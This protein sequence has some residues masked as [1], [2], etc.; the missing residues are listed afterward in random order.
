MQSLSQNFHNLE[1]F[2]NPCRAQLLPGVQVRGGA[3]GVDSIVSLPCA[4]RA[5]TVVE[6][7]DVAVLA[8]EYV[9]SCR[10]DPQWWCATSDRLSFGIPVTSV[11]WDLLQECHM[12]KWCWCM[13]AIGIIAEA[14]WA[15][16]V[17]TSI[18]AF[19]SGKCKP[20]CMFPVVPCL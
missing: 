15:D 7:C 11:Q 14:T 17:A 8:D 16:D 13:S 9:W 2:Y 18:S 10:H 5:P 4:A 6:D 12:S 1:T 20:T 19:Q 3:S